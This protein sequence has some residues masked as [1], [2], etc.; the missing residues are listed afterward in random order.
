MKGGTDKAFQSGQAAF[1]TNW[2]FVLQEVNAKGTPLYGKV[3]FIPFPTQN[4]VGTA[5]QGGN[6]LVVNAKSAHL[7]AAATLVKFILSPSQQQLRAVVSG[8]PPSVTSAY[9]PALFAK[10]PYFKTDLTVF[11]VGNPRPVNPRYK[12][13]STYIQDMLSSVL[14]NQQSPEDAL[15]SAAGKIAPLASSN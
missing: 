15:K 14:A 11:K 13:I 1:Q 4:G 10:A 7:A 2:P 6:E 5:T 12:Q 9:T 8:D 3:G